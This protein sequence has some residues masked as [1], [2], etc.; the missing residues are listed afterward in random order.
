GPATSVPAN[1][2]PAVPGGYIPPAGTRIPPPPTLQPGTRTIITPADAPP[3]LAPRPGTTFTPAPGTTFGAPPSGITPLPSNVFPAQP[4]TPGFGTPTNP[5]GS[6]PTQPQ[7]PPTGFGT[8][9][10][11]TGTNYV[12]ATDPYSATLTPA[13]SPA[14]A[15]S[16]TTPNST[17]SGPNHSV[18]GSGYRGATPARPEAPRASANDGV[19]RAPDLAPALPPSV[20]TVPDL[21]APQSPR[22]VNGAPQLLDPRDKTAFR[23]P[24]WA[25]VPAQ[26]PTKASASHQLSDR[27]VVQTKSHQPHDS[28]ITTQSPYINSQPNPAD[29]DDRGWK[30]AAF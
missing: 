5:G 23:D 16:T 14:D 17:Q 27:P 10:F 18:F 28:G 2:I 7:P 24:R 30:T 22:P 26:W 11:G 19:I 21:D 15:A 3:S 8:G 25:V 9:S 13:N 4:A 12:P 29:Y 1:V 6:F 20:Q